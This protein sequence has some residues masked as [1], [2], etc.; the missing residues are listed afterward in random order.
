MFAGSFFFLPTV[1]LLGL[2]VAYPISRTTVLSLFH[3]KLATHFQAKFA[4]LDNFVRMLSDSRL[5]NSLEV[6]NFFTAVSVALEFAAGLLLA[7]AVNTL[8]RGKG[9]VRTIVLVPWTLPTAI[10]AVLWTWI[11]NDQYGILNALLA[12]IATA[13][14][15]IAWLAKPNTAMAAMSRA[16]IS[17]R[18]RSSTRSPV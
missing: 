1:I 2:V 7:L 15:T 16:S 10:I 12:K 5:R 13:A 14:G 6:T 8:A 18:V 17:R 11:F 3:F 9:L 4:G